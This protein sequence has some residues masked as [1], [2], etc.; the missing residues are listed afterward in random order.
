[1][2]PFSL[3]YQ[4]RPVLETTPMIRRLPHLVKLLAGQDAGVYAVENSVTSKYQ[5]EDGFSLF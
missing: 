4:E 5:G 1:M 2:R 3:S